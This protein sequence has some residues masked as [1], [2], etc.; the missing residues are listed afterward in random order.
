[1]DKWTHKHPDLDLTMEHGKGRIEM[2]NENAELRKL[3]QLPLKQMALSKFFGKKC[4]S[5]R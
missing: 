1:M 5:V 3:D 4:K 2:H